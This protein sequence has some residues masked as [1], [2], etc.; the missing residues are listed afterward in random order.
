MKDSALTD[1]FKKA[2]AAFAD[3]FAEWR[4][5]YFFSALL[6]AV[7]ELQEQGLRATLDVRPGLYGSRAVKQGREAIANATVTVDGLATEWVLSRH[8]NYRQVELAAYAGDAQVANFASGYFT[9]K[10]VW[11]EPELINATTLQQALFNVLVDQLAARNVVAKYNTGTGIAPAK[12][13]RP[14]GL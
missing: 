10:D 11:N 14:R 3:Y 9:A 2:Q 13:Q 5:D 1:K 12:P 4:G 8:N 6:A 7:T